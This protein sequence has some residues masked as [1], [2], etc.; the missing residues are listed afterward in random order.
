LLLH[1]LSPERKL[2]LTDYAPASVERLGR[3]FPEAE[4]I[5]HNLIADP[6][7]DADLHLFH[8]IDTEFDNR[9]WRRIFEG[10]AERRILLVATE[11]VPTTELVARAARRLRPVRHRPTRAGWMRN[12]A[13]F[14]SLWKRTHDAE[15]LQLV[16]LQ[17]WLLAPRSSGS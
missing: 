4:V 15:P 11:V 13:S 2:V 7:V 16:D 9:R 12:R 1:R 10:F 17:G 6:P 14:D 8:R 3:L 5:V